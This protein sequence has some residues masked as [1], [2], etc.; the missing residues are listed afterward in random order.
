MTYYHPTEEAKDIIIG[1]VVDYLDGSCYVSEEDFVEHCREMFF[2]LSN[3]VGELKRG[4]T[5]T[6]EYYGKAKQFRNNTDQDEKG[7]ATK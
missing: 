4:E 2:A 6:Y 7:P 5:V 3:T 1:V